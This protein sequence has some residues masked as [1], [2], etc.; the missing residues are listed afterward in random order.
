MIVELKVKLPDGSKVSYITD[1]LCFIVK[2]SP[3]QKLPILGQNLSTLKQVVQDGFKLL[4][5]V[6]MYQ[7]QAFCKI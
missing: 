7:K 6:L 2:M 5:W 3:S 1:S 4:T